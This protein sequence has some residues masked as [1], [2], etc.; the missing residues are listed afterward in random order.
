MPKIERQPW[1]D[2]DAVTL[3]NNAIIV[4]RAQGSHSDGGRFDGLLLHQPCSDGLYVAYWAKGNFLVEEVPAEG[5]PFQCACGRMG[6]TGIDGPFYAE[7]G[8]D[9]DPR[10]SRC[11]CTGCRTPIT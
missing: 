9:R 11:R 2:G 7:S 6:V 4:G 1:R 8:F 5:A 3:L 10:D